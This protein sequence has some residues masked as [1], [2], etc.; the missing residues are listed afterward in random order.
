M[1][2]SNDET[3]PNPCGGDDGEH[4]GASRECGG[5]GLSRIL[6]ICAA[7]TLSVPI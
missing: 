7:R 2:D 3:S 4:G 6:A 1:T 5:D